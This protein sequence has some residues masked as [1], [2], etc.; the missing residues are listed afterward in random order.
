M[1]VLFVLDRF[2]PDIGG[3]EKL[4]K[5]LVSELETLDVD[6]SIFCC[7]HPQRITS[8][9]IIE[10][11]FRSRI[12]FALL[13]NFWVLY[14]SRKFDFLHSSSFFS[15]IACTLACLFGKKAILTYHEVWLDRWNSLPFLSKLQ[16]WQLKRLERSLLKVAFRR[17]VGVSNFTYRELLKVY[18]EGRVRRVVNAI[19]PMKRVSQTARGQTYL[20]Y[21]RLG[22]SKG[23]H[24]LKGLE[25]EHLPEGFQ[26][27]VVLPK[28]PSWLWEKVESELQAPFIEICD[29]LPEEDLIQLIESSKAVLIPSI[30]EGFGFAAAESCMLKTPLVHSGR[31][32]LPEV[33]HGP[34]VEMKEYSSKGLAQAIWAFE[35]GEIQMVENSLSNPKEMAQEYLKVYQELL[36]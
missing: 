18:P 8:S 1:K 6:V 29:E 14:H 34:V 22:V 31:G 4:F 36:P 15:G 3:S 20:M 5:L 35:R 30:S 16:K 28:S 26:L 2:D 21:G 11:P 33:V 25:Q 7:K 23:W 12:L 13:G 24:L 9:K 27:K 32:A 10:F 19:E 17:I